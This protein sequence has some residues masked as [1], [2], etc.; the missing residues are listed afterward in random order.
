MSVTDGAGAVSWPGVW[1][2]GILVFLHTGGVRVHMLLILR[3]LFF[4]GSRVFVE[5]FAAETLRAETVVV[6]RGAHSKRPL[7]SLKNELS[8]ARYYY[9]WS[10]VRS[11]EF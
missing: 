4:G 11:C 1:P 9:F 3:A 7:P 2:R 6:G 8:C 10:S 5:V